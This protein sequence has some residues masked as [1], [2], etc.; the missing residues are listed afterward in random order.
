MVKLETMRRSAEHDF[1]QIAMDSPTLLDPPLIG[2][3]GK[4]F[5]TGL[6]YI[7]TIKNPY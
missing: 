5:H 2:Q 1:I 4:W 6:L 7:A 3:T